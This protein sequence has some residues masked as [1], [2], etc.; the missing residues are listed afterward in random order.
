M[1]AFTGSMVAAV[2]LGVCKSTHIKNNIETKTILYYAKNGIYE[3]MLLL[4][5]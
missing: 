1:F 2:M 4:L 3:Y 5:M